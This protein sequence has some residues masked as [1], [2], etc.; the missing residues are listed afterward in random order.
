MKA[1]LKDSL[2]LFCGSTLFAVG[3][4]IFA[5][6][7][8]LLTGGA[9]GLAI[10]INTLTGI[11]VGLGILLINVPL[12]I[13]TTVICSFRYALKTLWSIVVF[14]L[15][16]AVWEDIIA[17]SYT[18]SY[19]L[20]AIMC[21]VLCG[22]GMY[23]LLRRALVTGGSDLLAYLINKKNP[24]RA[25]GPMIFI[26]DSAIIACGIFIYKDLQQLIF[27]ILLTFIMSA[28]M[29]VLLEKR[30]NAKLPE[31]NNRP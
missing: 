13:M 2:S 5:L 3:I 31:R 9:G 22:I 18:G 25:L 20:S 8:S 28:V 6:P 29:T 19:L 7:C 16:M 30:T 4:C 21:G 11:P 15:V 10:I 1:F 14:S 26:I 23:I 12:I 17:V 27:S 24:A